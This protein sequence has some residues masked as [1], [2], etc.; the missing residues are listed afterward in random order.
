MQTCHP[1]DG[2][3]SA[4]VRSTPPEQEVGF[5]GFIGGVISLRR[6][7]ALPQGALPA[8]P[9]FAKMPAYFINMFSYA[10]DWGLPLK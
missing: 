2:A 8:L 3:V 7:S 4:L 5:M 9:D 10:I 6:L 1:P